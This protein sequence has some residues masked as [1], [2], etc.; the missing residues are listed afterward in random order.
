MDGAQFLDL[1]RQMAPCRF[2]EAA[3]AAGGRA[4]DV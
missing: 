1:S 3:L 4:L 2:R